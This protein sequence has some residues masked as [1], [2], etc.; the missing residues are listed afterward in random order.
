MLFHFSELHLVPIKS[1]L[2]LRYISNL[3]AAAFASFF[4]FAK[5]NLCLLYA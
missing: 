1:L 2:A 5:S 3:Q 4:S